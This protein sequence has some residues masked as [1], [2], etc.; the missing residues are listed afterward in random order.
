MK[1]MCSPGPEDVHICSSRVPLP[2][3]APIFGR[4][5]GGLDL[6]VEE[7]EDEGS[8]S[9]VLHGLVRPSVELS[10]ASGIVGPPL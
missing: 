4:H 2:T 3:G 9:V 6:L 7:G 5:L 10:L 1:S 8:C